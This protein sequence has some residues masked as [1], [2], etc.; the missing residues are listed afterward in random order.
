MIKFR[1]KI[2][3]EEGK[4]R[5]TSNLGA[6]LSVIVLSIFIGLGIHLVFAGTLYVNPI[7]EAPSG[8]T[9]KP[10]NIGS[11]DQDKQGSL[12]VNE[13]FQKD[14]AWALYKSGNAIFTQ[15]VYGAIIAEGDDV[16]AYNY[17]QT[18]GDLVVG[19]YIYA[20]EQGWEDTRSAFRTIYGNGTTVYC[21]DGWYLKE[22]H[23][24]DEG[25]AS[26]D[27]ASPFRKYTPPPPPRAPTC[28]TGKTPILMA[29]A[30]YKNIADVQSGEYILTR[31]SETS[32]NL[33]PAKVLSTY[34]H[35]VNK[36]LVINSS[37]EVTFEHKMFVNGKWKLA[38]DIKIGDKLLNKDNQEVVV[39][40]IESRTKEKEFQVYNLEI[41]K[42]QTYFAG[43]FY[44]HN[45]KN[46]PPI[47]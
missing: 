21:G 38:G 19:E 31:E 43:E 28:F 1:F 17:M 7:Q 46:F 9:P 33:I 14:D 34:E 26:G 35:W 16:I 29:D 36:H 8:N 23:A 45:R 15:D 40:S 24:N 30:T 2:I 27:C 25:R 32:S 12:Y 3:V 13:L 37:L 22:F 4:T 11:G 44:V 6:I 39:E 10:I 47:P 5:K 18:F 20:P 41:E 42:Y